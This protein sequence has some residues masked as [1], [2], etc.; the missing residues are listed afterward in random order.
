MSY[1]TESPELHEKVD[2][3]LQGVESMDNLMPWI[4]KP[5]AKEIR[6]QMIKHLEKQISVVRVF[7]EVDGVKTVSDIKQKLNMQLSNVSRELGKLREI[8][9][10]EPKSVGNNTIYQKT[11]IDKVIGLSKELEKIIQEIDANKPTEVVINEKPSTDGNNNTVGNT[12][13]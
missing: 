13:S 3:I 11:K 2:K 9:I 4:I 6:D 5:H 7:L 12:Q 1:V 10:I 8:G